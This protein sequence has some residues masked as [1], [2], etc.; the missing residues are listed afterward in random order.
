MAILDVLKPAVGVVFIIRNLGKGAEL[1]SD[2]AETNQCQYRHRDNDDND[3]LFAFFF[4]HF[5][6]DTSGK[7]HFK[8]NNTYGLPSEPICGADKLI[9]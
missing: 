3:E 2:Q 9:N 5:H 4:G 8:V 1:G 7:L 6:R